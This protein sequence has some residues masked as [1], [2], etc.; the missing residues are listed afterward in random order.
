MFNFKTLAF[1]FIN[2]EV[3]NNPQCKIS[4]TLC[5][6]TPLSNSMK[7][8]FFFN[9]NSKYSLLLCLL[10]F[11]GSRRKRSPSTARIICITSRGFPGGA[12]VKE[13]ACQC[14]RQRLELDPWVRRIPWSGKW[15]HTPVF[16]PGK[17][18]GRGAWRATV[19]AVVKSQTQVSNRACRHKLKPLEKKAAI[20][21]SVP[22]CKIPRTEE[23]GGLQSMGLQRVRCH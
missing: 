1:S 12:R 3:H 21:S 23:P 10:V 20:H 4:N 15:Q 7:P 13:I 2:L 5:R 8:F 22:A 6:N 11:H 19:H 18:V 14:R 17:S 9:E 16:F